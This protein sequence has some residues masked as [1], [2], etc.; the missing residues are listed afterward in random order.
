MRKYNIHIAEVARLSREKMAFGRKCIDVCREV[1]P[2]AAEELQGLADGWGLS[3]QRFAAWIFCIY[4][5]EYKYGCTC[6]AFK[7][8]DN[9]IFGRNSDFFTEI[10]DVCESAL[11]LPDKGYRFIGNSTALVQMED[12]CNEHGLVIGLT[13]IPPKIL[14][15]GLNAGMLLRY[16]LEKC[17]TVKE[18]LKALE[19]LPISSAQTFTMV[20]KSGEMAA[21]EC[22]CKKMVIISPGGNENY[23]V[24]TNQFVS[25]EMQRYEILNFIGS[26]ERYG[27]A[28]QVLKTHKNYSCELARQ[29]LSGKYGVMCQ[30]ERKLEFDTLWSTVCDLKNDRI[31]RAEGNPTKARFKEDTRLRKAFE[32]RHEWQV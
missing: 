21:I 20:D 32:T 4:C 3:F 18:A 11:Y 31:F 29:I 2:E 19:L 14:K 12:G 10:R 16:V 30:Y 8:A 22:N 13:F 9:I 27:V 26:R 6:F 28:R 7:D 5:Y 17:R 25:P 23:L 1:Y 15:P 24:S